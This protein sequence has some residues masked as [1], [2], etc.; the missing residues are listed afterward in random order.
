[1]V[2]LKSY[3]FDVFS[4]Q[5]LAQFNLPQQANKCEAALA[6]FTLFTKKFG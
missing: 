5:T 4:P 2:L 3:S 1:V 6:A